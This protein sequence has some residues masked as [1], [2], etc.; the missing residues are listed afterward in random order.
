ML[1]SLEKAAALPTTEKI[2]VVKYVKATPLASEI[3]P[4]ATA[5]A[6]VAQVEETE[7][8]NSKTEQQPKLQSPSQ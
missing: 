4:A 8:K 6:T 1:H 7:P 5:K 2:E 3:I